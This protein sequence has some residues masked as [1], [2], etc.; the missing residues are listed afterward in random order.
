MFIFSILKPDLGSV[1]QLHPK[2]LD[3]SAHPTGNPYKG[4]IIERACSHSSGGVSEA[5]G[6]GCSKNCL[7]HADFFA[8]SSF[9]QPVWW[10][11][12]EV[13][14]SLFK[15]QRSV[16]NQ[17]RLKWRQA[18]P[19]VAVSSR[20]LLGLLCFPL[21]GYTHSPS[22]SGHLSVHLHKSGTLLNSES[23]GKRARCKPYFEAASEKGGEGSSRR[24][25][26]ESSDFIDGNYQSTSLSPSPTS[27]T[28]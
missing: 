11:G 18:F 14:V 12:E 25:G 15:K 19:V 4:I 23:S 21:A 9:P 27:S 10:V 13:C 22:H 3:P 17:E 16:L 1:K 6:L 5:V 28:T 2:R 8:C 7:L 26:R 24:E 20:S